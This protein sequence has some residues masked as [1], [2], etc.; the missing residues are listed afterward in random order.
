MDNKINSVTVFDKI[1][2][3]E[4]VQLLAAES[5]HRQGLMIH[6]ASSNN[7][8]CKVD[9]DAATDDYSF[10]LLPG[11]YYEMP[12]EYYTDRVTGI[13]DGTNGYAM[14]TQIKRS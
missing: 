2:A 10:K 14:V 12:L 5:G 11:A 6:N 9:A 4:S 8:F 3:S 1:A 13:W 7:L